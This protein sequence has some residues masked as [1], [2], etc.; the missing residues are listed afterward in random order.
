M[1]SMAGPLGGMA[2]SHVVKARDEECGCHMGGRGAHLHER[3]TSLVT[4]VSTGGRPALEVEAAL[5]GRVGACELLHG[6]GARGT[7]CN[8]HEWLD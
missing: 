5:C 3:R 4:L 2:G 8:A 6:I 1:R 7:S